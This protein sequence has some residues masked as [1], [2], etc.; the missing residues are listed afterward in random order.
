MAPAELEALLLQ[1]SEVADCGVVGRA[2]ELAGELPTAFVVRRPGS[3]VS[4]ADL[5]K[6]VA[7]KVIT[8]LSH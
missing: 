2:D 4:E 6:Y 7:S 8:T 5:V 3:D 1:H